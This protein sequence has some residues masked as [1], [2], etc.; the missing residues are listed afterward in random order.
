[1]NNDGFLKEAEL[2]AALNVQLDRTAVWR[3][4]KKG[5]PHI[6]IGK[7]IRYE[8]GAV[9]EWLASQPA[10]DEETIRPSNKPWTWRVWSW[11]NPMRWQGQ[12][13]PGFWYACCVGNQQKDAED[14]ARLYRGSDPSRD[15]RASINP[16]EDHPDL[17]VVDGDR[18][19]NSASKEG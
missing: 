17:G 16:P 19:Q 3:W 2:L 12:V 14:I 6:K 18:V 4:R 7:A 10:G 9:K 11:T 15:Y 13:E 1:M 5:M 8:L